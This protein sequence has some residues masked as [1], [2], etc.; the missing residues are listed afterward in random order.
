MPDDPR[1][2]N[3]STGSNISRDSGYR[4]SLDRPPQPLPDYAKPP[5]IPER[6]EKK[7]KKSKPKRKFN[8]NYQMTPVLILLYDF[9]V[10]SIYWSPC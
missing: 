2:S 1:K 10:V 6:P 7:E 8:K 9:E 4:S 3:V 5:P